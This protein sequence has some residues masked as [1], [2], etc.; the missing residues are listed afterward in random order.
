MTQDAV[1]WYA[2]NLAKSPQ[3]SRLFNKGGRTATLQSL[4]DQYFSL[5]GDINTLKTCLQT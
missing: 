2:L 5:E 4:S 3:V 1:I